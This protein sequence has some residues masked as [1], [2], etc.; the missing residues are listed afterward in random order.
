MNLW[1]DLPQL[2]VGKLISRTTG[3]SIYLLKFQV[4]WVDFCLEN[5]RQSWASHLV[6]NNKG[7]ILN[8]KRCFWGK[9]NNG[10]TFLKL[11]SEQ[12]LPLKM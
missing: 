9:E 11:Y 7:M 5:S 8:Q 10:R 1:T 4:D 6:N 12:Y 3:V 2:L